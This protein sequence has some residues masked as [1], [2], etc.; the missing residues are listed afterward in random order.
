[1]IKEIQRPMEIQS[2]ERNNDPNNDEDFKSF[3]KDFANISFQER[4][5][6][7]FYYYYQFALDGL[8][9]SKCQSVL[10]FGCADGVFIKAIQNNDQFLAV[11]GV[12][13]SKEGRVHTIKNTGI[14]PASSLENL[15]ASNFDGVVALEVLEHLSYPLDTLKKLF[16]M[17]N[18]VL[19]FT[20]PMEDKIKSEFHQ[21]QFKYYDVYNMCREITPNFKIYMINKFSKIGNPL[22]MFGAYLYKD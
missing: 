17:T 18:K 21:H 9:K 19:I 12:E 1:M 10:D 16:K 3:L 2:L 11:Y 8:I 6:K 7:H 20:V 15:S 14:E 22:N 4:L 13:I 5:E